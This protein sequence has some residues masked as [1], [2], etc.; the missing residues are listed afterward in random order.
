LVLSI[1]SEAR[2]LDTNDSEN[3]LE[4]VQNESGEWFGFN[5]FGNDDKRLVG[6]SSVLEELVD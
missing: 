5:V 4:F 1:V 2:G 6:L 3:S